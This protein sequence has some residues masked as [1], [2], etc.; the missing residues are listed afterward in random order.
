MRGGLR[1][2]DGSLDRTPLPAPYRRCTS[3]GRGPGERGA[4]PDL[5][6]AFA[7][8][9][10]R[11]RV[12]D[13]RRGGWLVHPRCSQPGCSPSGTAL[14]NRRG[15]KRFAS[16]KARPVRLWW[17]EDE[18]SAHGKPGKRPSLRL[19]GVSRP[20]GTE[21]RSP[22]TKKPRPGRSR[23][24]RTNS[25]GQSA[26]NRA[27]PLRG[28]VAFQRPRVSMLPELLVELL[29]FA[30][31]LR[32]RCKTQKGQKRGSGS[33]DSPQEVVLPG[34]GTTAQWLPVRQAAIRN[35]MG[36]SWVYPSSQK[37]AGCNKLNAPGICAGTRACTWEAIPSLG[38]G[39]ST[40]LSISVKPG[41]WF[42]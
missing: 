11:E 3:A 30:P 6:H 9:A 34:V 21:Q 37:S 12:K 33:H 14:R 1:G 22:H 42:R 26:T 28:E 27:Q 4:L 20:A 35:A 24:E 2:Q 38:S 18:D 23:F 19:L 15:T 40:R 25:G 41:T 17:A 29:C 10:P 36:G 39:C 13:R 5:E 7:G 16:K 8:A 32:L 31:E